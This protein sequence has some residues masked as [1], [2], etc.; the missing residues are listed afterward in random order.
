M[1]APHVALVHDNFAGPTGMGLI[2]GQHARWVLEDGWRLTIVGDNVPDDLRG[3]A[4]VVPA[5]KPRRLP[6]LPEH[7]EWSRRARHGMRRV[8]A[9]VVHCH[10]PLLAG[11]ADLLTTHFIS[12]AAHVRGVREDTTGAEGLLRRGQAWA[13]RGL[14]HAAY[15][16]IARTARISFVSEFLR[17]EFRALYGEPR[18]GWILGAPAPPWAPPSREERAAARRAFGAADGRIAAGFV[19]GT[20]PRKGY[21]E[22]LALANAPGVELLLAGPRTETVDAGGRPGLGFVD[23][24]AFLPACDVLLSPSS[25]DSAPVAVLQALARGVPVVSSPTSGWAPVLERHGAGVVWD[26]SGPLADA[27]RAAAAVP[28]SACRRMVESLAPERQKAALL[29][30]YREILGE[31]GVETA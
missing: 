7:L 5:H 15:R 16:R 3:A 20:D 2:L 1:T 31:K 12:H 6:S 29:A 13:S 27:V 22:A 28:A 17:D 23:M 18:G 10:S 11:R 19:G 24:E 14:D 30:V 9:D 25:F 4:L 21:R 26:G 8:R